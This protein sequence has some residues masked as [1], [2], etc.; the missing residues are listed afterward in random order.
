MNAEKLDG[1]EDG[2]F[3]IATSMFA[4]I[5]AADRP[6]AV[7]E[8]YRVLKP[9]GLAACAGWG[10]VPTVDWIHLSNKVRNC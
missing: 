4:M 7:R 9:G 10:P 6:A 5:F 2:S 8:T 3:D 1:I